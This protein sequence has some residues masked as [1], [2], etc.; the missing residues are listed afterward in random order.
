[1]GLNPSQVS[2]ERGHY[3]ANPRNRFWRAFN[4]SGLVSTPVAM[5]DDHRLTSE[6]IG[7][8]DLVKRPSRQASALR[9]KDYREGAPALK[10][11]ILQYK[12]AVVC[13]Q[14]LTVYGNYLR[15]AEGLK[16]K[17]QLGHQ[18]QMIGQ[19]QVFVVPNPSPTNAQ[20][21]L[22]TLVCWLRRLKNLRDEIRGQ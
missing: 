3:F 6:G 12:P 20:Y 1:M 10:E 15:Y 7:F 18:S 19:S 8:T 11:K 4:R 9:A 13:F 5:E 22:E 21:S 17:P 16:L 14:G 2:V